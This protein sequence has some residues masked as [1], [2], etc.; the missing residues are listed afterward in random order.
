MT[1]TYYEI[2]ED[3]HEAQVDVSAGEAHGLITAWICSFG[4]ESAWPLHL[5]ATE[6][7]PESLTELYDLTKKGLNADDFSFGMLLPDDDASL[8]AF[9]LAI[10]HWCHGFVSGLGLTEVDLKHFPECQEAISDLIAISQIDHDQVGN[11]E[12]SERQLT[13]ITEFV[14][15]AVLLIKADIEQLRQQH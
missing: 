13:D 11:S 14:R 10:T 5:F 7:L 8:S 12:E 4:S 1:I 2:D 3:L 15:M 9:A 6:S